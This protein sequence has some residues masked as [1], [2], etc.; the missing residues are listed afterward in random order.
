[1][2]STQ[3]EQLPDA[4]RDL[5]AARHRPGPSVAARPRARVAL[6]E[7]EAVWGGQPFIKVELRL[8]PSAAERE[9]V[10]ADLIDTMVQSARCP[11][12]C[13]SSSSSCGSSR[14]AADCR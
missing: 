1:M 13:G 2:G 3:V 4:P 8:P 9:A 6:P 14:A 7:G 5:T 11:A 12:A 10:A